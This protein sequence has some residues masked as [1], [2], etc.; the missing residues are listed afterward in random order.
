MLAVGLVQI[1]SF[2]WLIAEFRGQ[3]SPNGRFGVA[4]GVTA[5]RLLLVAT[6][7]VALAHIS[8]L[9]LALAVIVVLALDGVDGWLARRL[10]FASEFGGHFD[11][12]SDAALVLVMTQ[13]LWLRHQLG[14]WIVIPGLLR[15]MFVLWQASGLASRYA[16]SRTMFGRVAFA[17]LAIGVA[18]A[19]QL[20]NYWRVGAAGIG[21][22]LVVVSFARG[23]MA[24]LTWSTK[25]R[26][27]AAQLRAGNAPTRATIVRADN[28][29]GLR[30]S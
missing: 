7:A 2:L 19:W 9:A 4:N 17:A 15:P 23:F 21:S 25:S 24:T 5:V 20:P 1:A 10:G 26:A 16:P 22:A 8:N 18:A 28:S 11:M 30:Q 6:C 3:W 12:E 14:F 29:A 13:A 27:A